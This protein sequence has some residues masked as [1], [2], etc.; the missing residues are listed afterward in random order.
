MGNNSEAKKFFLKT[1][2]LQKK[3]G[4]TD[5]RLVAVMVDLAKIYL[6]EGNFEESLKLF[7]EAYTIMKEHRSK[8]TAT[9]DKKRFTMIQLEIASIENDH[10]NRNS[11]IQ[12]M[13]D[14]RDFLKDL[15][16][17]IDVMYQAI[18]IYLKMGQIK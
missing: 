15:K 14:A 9:P 18:D 6:K 17:D 5:L 7:R 1:I 12:I 11:A 4:E 2:D 16:D 8:C 10:G 3:I 13:E